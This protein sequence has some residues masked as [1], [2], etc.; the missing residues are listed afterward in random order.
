M[1]LDLRFADAQ[2]M[3]IGFTAP[4]IPLAPTSQLD[5]TVNWAQQ[6]P[7]LLAPFESAQSS[8]NVQQIR[9]AIYANVL[10]ILAK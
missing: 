6:F 4:P 10:K 3:G 8:A 1:E 9:S 5:K 7:Y 2:S